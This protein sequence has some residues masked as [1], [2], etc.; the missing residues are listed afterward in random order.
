MKKYFIE[1]IGTFFLVFTAEMTLLNGTDKFSPLAIGGIL[2]IMT[3]AYWPISGAHFN[4][5]ISVANWLS[6]RVLKLEIAPYIAA[7]VVA[8]VLGSLVA[9]F[10]LSTMQASLPEPR[11]LDVVPAFVAEFIG[12][13]AL[14]LIYLQITHQNSKNAHPYSGLAIGATLTT[15]I[16]AVNNISGGIF[17][18]AIA[19]GA[20]IVETASW[21]H[22]W[23]YFIS[24]F[25]A[26][27]AGAFVYRFITEDS[28]Y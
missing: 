28:L 9:G 13:S 21:G 18:P 5:A 1:F 2:M 26:A 3:Y 22:L 24:Q 6:G 16:Y 23:L 17:N 10:L 25:G 14:V 4:P 8:A 20:C 19:I 15:F 27:L 12:T 11:L 7:Q